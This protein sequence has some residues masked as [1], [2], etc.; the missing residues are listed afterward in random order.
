MGLQLPCVGALAGRPARPGA[1]HAALSS[2]A[3]PRMDLLAHGA[4][5]VSSAGESP[6]TLPAMSPVTLR[7]LLGTHAGTEAL[8][9][10]RVS[11]PLVAFEYD[12]VKVVNTRFKAMMRDLQYDFG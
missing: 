7:S 12:D 9:A 11:S 1:G 10:G 4:N 3:G 5:A 2:G 8:K 6:M